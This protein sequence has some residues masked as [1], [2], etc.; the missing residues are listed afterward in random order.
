MDYLKQTKKERNKQTKNKKQK[1][2]K[3]KNKKTPT[4]GFLT[5]WI[6]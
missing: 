1:T 6:L 4:T 2:P 3:N 5:F